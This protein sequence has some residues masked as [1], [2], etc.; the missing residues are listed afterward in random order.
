MKEIVGKEK[1]LQVLH[2]KIAQD[3][4]NLTLYQNK[5]KELLRRIEFMKRMQ[6]THDPHKQKIAIQKTLSSPMDGRLG[7][8]AQSELKLHRQHT[9]ESISIIKQADIEEHQTDP[10]HEAHEG[11]LTSGNS[12]SSEIVPSRA[13]GLET[14]VTQWPGNEQDESVVSQEQ[15]QVARELVQK[16]R[17]IFEL[18]QVGDNRNTGMTGFIGSTLHLHLSKAFSRNKQHWLS[19][20][21]HRVI[22]NGKCMDSKCYCKHNCKR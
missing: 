3:Q 20:H 18:E 1:E 21:K 12:E 6:L 22:C 7:Q 8:N 2:K 4:E 13:S 9:V 15:M 11:D 10:I 17:R 19:L 14:S 5:N 16:N